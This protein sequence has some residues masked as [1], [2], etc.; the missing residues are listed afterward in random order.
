MSARFLPRYADEPKCA[1]LDVA[2]SRLP[3]RQAAG[4]RSSSA[5]NQSAGVDANPPAA[6]ERPIASTPAWTRLRNR[7]RTW[8]FDPTD[9]RA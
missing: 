4:G 5:A 1:D 3:V 9:L 7:L 6:V 8:P 2:A